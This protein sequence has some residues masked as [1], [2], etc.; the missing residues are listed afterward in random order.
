VVGEDKMVRK[1]EIYVNDEGYSLK[2]YQDCQ[3]GS[4]G[5]KPTLEAAMYSLAE[6][7]EFDVEA[8]LANGLQYPDFFMRKTKI[9]F[10]CNPTLKR[11]VL[12]ELKAL[13]FDTESIFVKRVGTEDG[14]E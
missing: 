3:A 14:R 6:M 5:R 7:L 8:S 1:L 11:K 4:S 12:S 2:A 10:K 9:E 13:Q